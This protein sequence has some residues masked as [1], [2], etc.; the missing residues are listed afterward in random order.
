MVADAYPPMRTSCAVQMYDLGQAFIQAGHQVT[1]I[2]PVST[3]VEKVRIQTQDGVRLVQ[4]RALQTKDVNYTQRT[5]AEWANPFVIWQHL[6]KHPHFISAQY[7]GVIWY[8]PTIFWGPLIKRLK[9]YFQIPSYLIL[10]DI[11][12]DW[13]IDLGILKKGP[14]YLFLKRVEHYQYRQANTIGVQSPNNLRYFEKNNPQVRAK[15]EV[16]WNWNGNII[17]TPCSI[18]LGKTILSGRKVF[19][20]AGN[21]GVAQAMDNLINLADK[22]KRQKEFGFVFVGR[23]SELSRLK[24]IVKSKR[25]DNVLFFDEINTTEIPGLYRQCNVGMISLDVKHST[26]NIPGKFLTYVK[27]KLPIFAIGNPS[28]DLEVL[29]EKYSLGVYVSSISNE[30]INRTLSIIQDSN[31]VQKNASSES[32]WAEIERLFS[33]ANSVMQ[34]IEGIRT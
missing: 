26:H 13:A 24:E 4:V 29:I 20:Y 5:I 14:A 27:S 10:R 16:L 1:M 32:K 28:N 25:L 34:I 17:E 21:M 15:I 3:Q 11:F 33:S 19:V 7:D 30:S 8:S 12:P 2:V 6:K 31:R 9:Q 18:D 22:L 23:G